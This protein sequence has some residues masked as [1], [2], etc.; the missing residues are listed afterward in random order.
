M[1]KRAVVLFLVFLAGIS[2]GAGVCIAQNNPYEIDDTCYPAYV[3]A[4]ELTDTC[5][6]AGGFGSTGK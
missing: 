1:K 3:E 5:R 4:E 2:L 6:A